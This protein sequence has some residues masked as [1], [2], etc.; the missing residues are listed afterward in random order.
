MFTEIKGKKIELPGLDLD[1]IIFNGPEQTFAGADDDTQIIDLSDSRI[2]KEISKMRE[3]AEV[4]LLRELKENEDKI[5]LKALYNS[6][7]RELKEE[8]R[9]LLEAD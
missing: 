7:Y 8:Y 5:E 6:T 2:L 3:I 4:E 9:R 1:T